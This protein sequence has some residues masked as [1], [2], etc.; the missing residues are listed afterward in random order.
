MKNTKKTKEKSI[1]TKLTRILGVLT[2]FMVIMCVLNCSAWLVIKDFNDALKQNFRD[3]L[4]A[5]ASM[6]VEA[7]TLVEGQIAY[8]FEHSDIKADGTFIFNIVLVVLAVTI[9]AVMY[10]VMIKSV[11]KP[12]RVVNDKIKVIANGDL[13]VEFDSN[14]S[15]NL[16]SKDEVICMQNSMSNMISRLKSI[17]KNVMDSS[18]SVSAAMDRLN[19]GS[20]I[21]SQST[22]DIELAITEVAK[23]AVATAEDTQLATTVVSDI[24]VNVAGIKDSTEGLSVAADNMNNAK[25]NVMAILNEF[26]IVNETMEQN[27]ND[28]NEQ[29]SITSKNVKEIQKF[30]EVI[31]DIASKTNLLSLNASIEASHAGE[32]GK[33]FAV[34]ASEIRKLAE[35]SSNSASEIEIALNG[36]L[37]NYE[38]IVHKMNITNGNIEFQSTKLEET[39]QNFEVLDSDINVT[40]GK[41]SEIDSMVYELDILRGKLVDVIAS[42]SA[43]SEENA[44][45]AEETTARNQ[46]LSATITAMCRDIWDVKEAAHGLLNSINVFKI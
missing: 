3:Y 46:E 45:S 13:T 6:D 8:T 32:A 19:D 33:G 39:R 4:E 2:V 35:Q 37:E 7:M 42:L 5:T 26:I 20:E 41:I 25:N 11:T 44:A 27:V 9:S 34:V 10:L 31:K 1:N 38:S 23:G 30:I 22:S 43:V 14:N 15:N 36:L 18:E 29:I 28:T 21:I 24:G 16:D 12:I 40:V 17:V